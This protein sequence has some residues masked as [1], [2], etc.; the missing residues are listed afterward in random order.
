MIEISF[1]QGRSDEVKGL[2]ADLNNRLVKAVALRP[3]DVFVILHDVGPANV[4]FGR[5]LAQKAP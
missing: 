3:D 4:S 1:I 5:G 2:L